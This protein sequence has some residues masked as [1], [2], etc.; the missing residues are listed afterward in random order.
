MVTDDAVVSD[1]RVAEEEV[2]IADRGGGVWRGG[3]VDGCVFA[4]G[5]SIANNE[6]SWFAF[7]FQILRQ[8]ANRSEWKEQVIFADAGVSIDH[9]MGFKNGV[10]AQTHVIT[11]D[12]IRTNR[13]VF[14]D[15]GGV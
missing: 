6:I 4:E 12:A 7:V 3:A 15:G 2:V 5:V 10:I 1:V 14:A 11:D 8:L 13:N 9:D